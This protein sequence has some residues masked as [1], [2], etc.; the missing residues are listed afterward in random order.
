M[1]ENRY[2]RFL[3]VLII[4]IAVLNWLATVF[5]LYWR[6]G[7]FDMPM[8]FLGGA[9]VSA[10][11]LWFF[12]LSGRFAMKDKY[13]SILYTYLLSV[14]SVIIIGGVWELFE[15]GVDIAVLSIAQNNII[16][17]ASD[18]MFDILGALVASS[19]FV[20]KSRK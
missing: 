9:W 15:F 7:W 10:T 6:V 5:S 4:V 20:L 1:E 19:Y 8:H 12:I 16:D 14:V 13:K 18:M 2:P 11:T 3:L 17:T